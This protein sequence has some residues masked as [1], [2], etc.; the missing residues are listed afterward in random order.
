MIDQ[1]CSLEY[2]NLTEEDSQFLLEKKKT[3]SF[4][5]KTKDQI[6]ND[7]TLYAG[8]PK[9]NYHFTF[10]VLSQEPRNGFTNRLFLLKTEIQAQILNTEPFLCD[11][12]GL[13]Y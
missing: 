6:I 3:N 13:R 2:Q 10:C 4:L 5:K 8:Y 7:F 12:R 11:Y 1:L 9:R